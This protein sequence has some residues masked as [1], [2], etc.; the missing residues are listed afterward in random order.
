[1]TSHMGVMSQWTIQAYTRIPIV[2]TWSLLVIGPTLLLVLHG[3]Y[4]ML[5]LFLLLHAHHMFCT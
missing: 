4:Y 3:Y 2:K 1:M 5:L